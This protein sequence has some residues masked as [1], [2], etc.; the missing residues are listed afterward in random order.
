MP[1]NL[2]PVPSSFTGD[3]RRWLEELRKLVNGLPVVSFGSFATPNS[4]VSGA[5]TDLFVNI[6]STSTSTRLWVKTGPENLTI[7]NTSWSAIRI[8][9]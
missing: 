5:L 2:R 7:S 6:G 4:N 8:L 1:Y 9:P 3:D